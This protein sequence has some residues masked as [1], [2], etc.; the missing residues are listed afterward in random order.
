MFNTVEE[1]FAQYDKTIDMVKNHP[2]KGP[3]QYHITGEGGGDWYLL[4]NDVD[5]VVYS[6]RIDNPVSVVECDAAT[7][8]D[9]KNGKV[10]HSEILKANKMK[11]IKGIKNVLKLS[12]YMVK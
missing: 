4:I 10:G 3:I 6:G 11:L 1:I 5:I 12:E 7:Y 9:L 8:L 2:V